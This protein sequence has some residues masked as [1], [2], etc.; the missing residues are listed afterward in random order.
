MGGDDDEK[1]GKTKYFDGSKPEELKSWKM[2]VSAGLL[3][4]SKKD[5]VHDTST[6]GPFI[7]K[8]LRGEAAES[9]RDHS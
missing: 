4:Q 7:I 3:S 6:W 5:G 2:T 8:F 9:G 1:E